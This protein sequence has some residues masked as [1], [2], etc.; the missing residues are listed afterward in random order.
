MGAVK[1]CGLRR[2]SGNKEIADWIAAHYDSVHIGN[3]AGYDLTKA[4]ALNRR[5]IAG[6]LAVV[7]MPGHGYAR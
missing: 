1:G 2:V 6:G 4:D 3:V 7:R 5:A